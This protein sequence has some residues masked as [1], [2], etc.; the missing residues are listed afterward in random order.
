MGCCWSRT[1]GRGG[2]LGIFCG[3]LSFTVI[4]GMDSREKRII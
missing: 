2:G 3:R 4:E 1:G